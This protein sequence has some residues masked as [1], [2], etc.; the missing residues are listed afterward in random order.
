AQSSAPAERGWPFSPAT[1]V[2]VAASL[3]GLVLRLLYFARPGHLLGVTEYDDG[4]YFGAAVRLVHGVVP[5]KDFILV[6]PPGV[7]LLMTPVA[8]IGKLVGSGWAMGTGRLLTACAGAASVLLSG[9]LV[10]RRGLLAVIITCG[11]MAV[12]PDAILAAHTVL[13]EPWL[14]LA[15]LAG[16]VAVFEDE[17]LTTSSK[18]LAWGGVAFGFAGAIKVWAVFPVVVIAIMCAP[19]I[20]RAAI[21]LGGVIAG[22]VVPVLPFFIMDPSSFYRGVILAQLVRTDDVRV[23]LKTRLADLSGIVSSTSG[24]VK[25][26]TAVA[27]LVTVLILL[28][29]AGACVG[30]SVA[31]K[32]LPPPLE[33]FVLVTG[34]IVFVSF[35]WPV[36]FYYHYAGF[37]APFLALAIALPIARL[38]GA[39]QPVVQRRSPGVRLD[40]VGLG[41]AAI[42]LLGMFIAQV[43]TEASA[44]AGWDPAAVADK[45]IPPGACVLTDQVSMTIVAGRFTSTAANCPQIVDGFGTDIDLSNGHNGDTGAA[46]T[47]A[48]RQVWDNAF[49]HAQYVWL[50]SRPFDKSG[51]AY[52][53][54]AWTPTLKAYFTANFHRVGSHRLYLYKRIG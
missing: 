18:R 28:L 41:L 13:Q 22:F 17:R 40:Q 47:A 52:R 38:A 32:R 29:I 48:V 33:I 7:V 5:Y 11:I 36:D 35:L 46:R 20:R 19:S 39:L 34:A 12:Y 3:L 25:V 43:T 15:C 49:R 26:S 6:Q 45:V 27:G 8:A 1:A 53:R 10:R 30:A 24:T 9:L 50:S 44:K 42:A 4:V 14:V 31:T 16:L 23:A 54:I 37:F 51:T 2:I 21:Y